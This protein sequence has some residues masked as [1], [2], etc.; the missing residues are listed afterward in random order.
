M[1][2]AAL[3]VVIAALFAGLILNS[4]LS[5]AQG[6]E[7]EGSFVITPELTEGSLSST[8]A[9]G[10]TTGSSGFMLSMGLLTA[11]V[12]WVCGVLSMI[13]SFVSSLIA[14]VLGEAI[15]VCCLSPLNICM[16]CLCSGQSGMICGALSAMI[17]GAISVCIGILEACVVQFNSFCG[18]CFGGVWSCITSFL[19]L[20][21][22]L[23]VD[24]IELVIT[25]VT[26]LLAAF[27][28]CAIS[29]IV[30]LVL[31]IIDTILAG[32]W[33]C[34]TPAWTLIVD[35]V[36][37]FI[38][39]CG[40]LI[41]EIIDLIAGSVEAVASLLEACCASLFSCAFASVF[42]IIWE[43]IDT[44]MASV[45]DLIV[46]FVSA[47]NAFLA[48]LCGSSVGICSGIVASCIS[49]SGTAITECVDLIAGGAEALA[50]CLGFCY[51]LFSSFDWAGYCAQACGLCTW[52]YA[53][54][55]YECSVL[56]LCI[57]GGLYLTPLRYCLAPIHYQLGV[58]CQFVS[59]NCQSMT[60]L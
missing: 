57:L 1:R 59:K 53:P 19:A 17:G 26:S 29:D 3:T 30:A 21:V 56:Y 50:S 55:A 7:A 14:T 47:C 11:G 41:T 36:V 31:D 25:F 18:T 16:S 48:G 33:A 45:Q 42:D 13:V 22:A 37:L 20:G 6:Q 52:I 4:A 15:N 34:I 40:T 54:C 5:T 39:S 8:R 27:A 23:V 58:L 12:L 10:T 38:S 49:L 9:Q 46:W 32:I 2:S 35:L 44:C 43:F 60:P 28:A 24:F 51:L